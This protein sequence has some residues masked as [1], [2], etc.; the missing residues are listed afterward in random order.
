MAAV[1][2]RHGDRV[3]SAALAFYAAEYAN[4]FSINTLRITK[5]TKLQ[6]S[7]ASRAVSK[8]GTVAQPPKPQV[9][10][11]EARAKMMQAGFTSAM[12]QV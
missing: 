11:G 8:S 4:T 7:P 12:M 10:S 9:P 2:E 6:S 3:Q 1:T 5:P